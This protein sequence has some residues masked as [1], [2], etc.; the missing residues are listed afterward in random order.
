M[1]DIK[2]IGLVKIIILIIVV[3]AVIGLIVYLFPVMRNLSTHEG[4]VAFK[5]KIDNS[6]IWGFLILVGLQ[7]AQIFL[8]IIPGEPLEILAGMCYGAIGGT[9]F[10]LFSV[11]I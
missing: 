6:G 2:R 9:I 11:A 3:I 5:E 7:F 1:E 4:Q 8:V 10:A